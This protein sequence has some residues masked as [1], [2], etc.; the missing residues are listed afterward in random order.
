MLGRRLLLLGSLAALMVA[1][2]PVGPVKAAGWRDEIK[3]IRFGHG[4]SGQNI[5]EQ[6][7]RWK[8]LTEYMERALGVKATIRNTTDYAAIIEAQAAGFIDVAH[9]GPAGY[10]AAYQIM[11]GNL[12]PCCM[13]MSKKGYAGYYGI[14]VVKADSPYQTLDDLDGK[15][16][17]Y[18]DPNSTSGY[19]VPNHYL[20][21]M[22]KAPDKYFSKTLFA[23]GSDAGIF[24]LLQGTVDAAANYMYDENNSGY[25]RM[26]RKKVISSP[27]LLRTIWVSPLIPGAGWFFRKDLPEGLKQEVTEALLKMHEVE[28][29]NW[30][31]IQAGQV[32]KYV[33][34][35]HE[36]Y[37]DIIAMREKLLRERKD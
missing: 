19:L 32:K 14:I 7:V 28:P 37:A 30:K 4:G 25:H 33:P 18:T 11:E 12:E 20:R 10:A 29:E 26:A 1:G 31:Q 23:G 9:Y 3:V 27:D 35:S 13:E 36:I 16:F 24:A 17:A 21:K 15:V 8:P 2:S 5:A 22:G 6:V 34:A